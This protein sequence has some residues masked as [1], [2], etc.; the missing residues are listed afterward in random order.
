MIDTFAINM[1]A[2]TYM[3]DESLRILLVHEFFHAGMTVSMTVS[4][5]PTLMVPPE[6]VMGAQRLLA[7]VRKGIILR[8][9]VRTSLVMA[10][11]Q[12]VLRIDLN[13]KNATNIINRAELVVQA[14]H[15]PISQDVLSLRAP[16]SSSERERDR[17]LNLS[18]QPALAYEDTS[19]LESSTKVK[20]AAKQ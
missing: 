13:D 12:E 20:M 16:T 9:L 5:S 14:W 7:L 15:K 18:I 10:H 4:A 3:S 6:R 2:S 1:A 19:M 8:L 11:G 17:E